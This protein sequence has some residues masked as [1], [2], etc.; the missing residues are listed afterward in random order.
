MNFKTTIY[1]IFILINFS[2]GKFVNQV[3][4]NLDEKEKINY[5]PLTINNIYNFSKNNDLINY[6]DSNIY[7]IDIV[8]LKEIIK[9]SNKKLHLIVIYTENC[10]YQTP[11]IREILNK[12]AKNE[13]ISLYFICP[14]D[15]IS[16]LNIKKYWKELGYSKPTYIIDIYQFPKVNKFNFGFKYRYE[17]FSTSICKDC[18]NKNESPEYYLVNNNFEILYNNSGKLNDSIIDF[19]TK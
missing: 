10:S 13:N 2:C 12:T 5:K 19:I 9:F 7:L 16:T 11:T 6:I 17:A 14:S 15:W 4:N 1:F 3:Y 18:K 8:K